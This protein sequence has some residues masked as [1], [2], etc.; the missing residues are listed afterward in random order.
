MDITECFP[1]WGHLSIVK[2]L[3]TEYNKIIINFEF[4]F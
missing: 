2:T 3:E 1:L 4:E